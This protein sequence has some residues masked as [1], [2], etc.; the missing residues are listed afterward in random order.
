MMYRL[1]PFLFVLWT[2][3]L[4]AQIHVEQKC[5]PSLQRYW[6]K[7]DVRKL[8]AHETGLFTVVVS[9]VASFEQWALNNGLAIVAKHSPSGVV[10]IQDNQAH[11][12]DTTLQLSD[13]LFADFGY[14]NAREETSVPGHNLYVNN[15]AWVQR[16]LP[17][18][19]GMGT[20]LSIKE[21]RFDSTDVD[22]YGRYVPSPGSKPAVDAHPTLMATLAVG[23][24][25]SN[26]AG[27]GAAR[28]S[29]LFSSDYEGLLPDANG[30]YEGFDIGVQNHSYGLGIENYYGANALAYDQSVVENPGVVHVFS[31][32]NIGIDTPTTGTYTG[33]AGFANLT[34]NFKMAKN[35]LTVGA[36]DSFYQ[37][38]TFS[39]HGPAYDGRTKPD[40]VAFGNDGTSHA[41]ALVSGAAAVVRQVYY[42]KADAW[43]SSAAVRAVLLG[44]ADDLGASGPDFTSGFGNLNLKK[45]VD[46]VQNQFVG[47]GD[48]AQSAT[49]EYEVVIPANVQ[50]LKTTLCWND[51]P[52][53]PNAVSA[54]I[55]DLDLTIRT[56][57]GTVLSPWAP[58]PRPDSLLVPARSGRDSINNAEQVMLEWPAPGA[59]KI[60]V[61]GNKI[62]GNSAQPFA[63]AAAWDTADHFEWTSPLG[64][65]DAE[66]G[67]EAVLRW[68]TTL[69]HQKGRLA[70]KT[71][72]SDVWLTIDPEVSL[73]PGF[74]KWTL[75]DTFASAQVR[76]RVN[77]QD[78]VSDTFLIGPALR[79][80]TVFFCPD[81]FMLVWNQATTDAQYKLWVLGDNYLQP[82][83]TTPDT[84]VVLQTEDYPQKR[85]AVSALYADGHAESNTSSAPDASMNGA[86]CYINS[87]YAV[88]NE[89]GQIELAL[90]L[91]TWYG[92]QG[93]RFEKRINGVWS[94]LYDA[95]LPSAFPVTYTD[96]TPD[97]GTN[98][99]R[100]RLIMDN[101]GT[102]TST[103]ETVYYAGP[104]GFLLWPNPV[105]PGAS[106]TLLASLTDDNNRF[107]LYDWMGKR[108]MDVILENNQ[109]ILK[110]PY[111]PP[112]HYVWAINN[113]TGNKPER[114]KLVVVK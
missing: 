61:K 21:Y 92:L 56:P 46:L 100:A 60:I 17:Q 32:G 94:F 9:N 18:F 72:G 95:N 108:V 93:I 112:G 99:Y 1:L 4:T 105:Q 34:G 7:S 111:L 41:A 78:Y 73:D 15:I 83:F 87:F 96:E 38:T 69:E 8:Q 110:L 85:F 113:G 107:A 55:N 50:R 84:V 3:G 6:Q 36:V 70:W 14:R 24:G 49:V 53:I 52:A 23:A 90:N 58:D 20:T 91:G 97:Q 2:T 66:Q 19:N 88:L 81:T 65:H 103:E 57:N 13:V 62:P 63:F 67:K 86:E 12:H 64:S 40:L 77:G 68:E 75:P 106:I 35:I 114:G 10:V 28:G 43:P 104:S 47:I 37:V 89:N 5:S 101:G 82:F 44:S 74:K 39:S 29:K 48:V 30:V 16:K 80:H 102:I 11:F 51:P 109:T 79:L 42:E 31:A 59:Y 27:R 45:A 33:M 25:N 71:T 98:T 26:P 22:F 54:L 76:M